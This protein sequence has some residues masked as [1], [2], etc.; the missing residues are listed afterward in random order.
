MSLSRKGLLALAA[1]ALLHQSVGAVALQTNSRADAGGLSAA[2]PESVGMSGD[3]LARIAGAIQ[4]TVEQGEIPGAVVLVARQGRI[5]YNQAVGYKSLEPR[6]EPMSQDTVFDMASLTKVVATATSMMILVEHGKLSLMDAVATYIPEFG[7]MGKEQVTVEQ[8]LTHRAGLPP[9]NEITDYIGKTV[10]PMENIYNLR[11]VYQPGT[12]FSYSDVGYIVA[13][14]IVRR[15]SGKRL[16]QFAMDNVFKP[17]GMTSTRF[18]PISDEGA[19]PESRGDAYIDRV[20]PTETRDGRRMKGEVHDPRSFA[21]GGVAGHAGLFS[22]AADLAIF[23]QMILNEGQYRGARILSPYAVKRMVSS[24][25]LPQSEMRGIGWDLNTPYSSNRGDLFPVGSFGHTGFTGNSVWIDPWSKTFVILLTDRVHPNG[26]GS[27]S[28][29][30][31]LVA[32]IVAG[33]I[34]APPYAPIFGGSNPDATTTEIPRAPVTRLAPVGPLHPVAAGIDVLESEKFKVL[35]GRHIGL[36]TNQTGRDHA[37]RSTIDILAAASNLKLVAIFSPEHGLRGVADTTV[38]NSRDEK[39]GLPV[40]SLFGKGQ[41]R[42][43]PEMLAGIDTLV[44][45]IQDVGTR[46]YTYTTTCGY[47]MEAAAQ[48]KL[49]FVVLDRPNPIGGHEIEGPVAETEFT[50][51]PRHSFTSYYTIPV[52]YGLTI[53]ELAMLLNSERKIGADLT[54]VK[55]EGWR[56]ADYF[57]GTAL[58]WTSPS[59]NMRNLNEA[60]LYPGI[61]LLETTN[62]SV[63]RGT[64]T[65]FEVVGAPWVEEQRL[66][67]A[68]NRAGLPGA[69]FVPI[70]FTPRSSIYSDQECGGVNILVTDRGAF[71]PV[72][73]GLQIAYELNRLYPAA[74]KIDDYVNLLANRPVLAALKAGKTPQEIESLWQAGL[75]EFARIRMKYLIY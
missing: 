20:A 34:T 70:R 27:D 15:V 73:V 60:I 49:K 18:L 37:G 51:D 4:Q 31:T 25:R 26:K 64:D 38:D 19:L 6:R 56:R 71:R 14:E 22:T 8:L 72:A 61:G 68:L 32:S 65:P 67:D 57:D 12:R 10:D 44:Y 35:E 33:S 3:R 29:L 54:V 13:A 5:V 45:D 53:G 30:R 52:R 1:C 43:T 16:D 48:N 2:S 58:T 42:P 55:I 24:V 75:V 11:P 69:R 62:V 23:C 59:P 40:Y 63:G 39:T 46:F 17:L 47:S 21:L 28:R 66:S 50:V 36:I 9:D 74:W 7:R 41:R